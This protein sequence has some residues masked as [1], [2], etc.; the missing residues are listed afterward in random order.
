[1]V[2]TDAGYKGEAAFICNNKYDDQNDTD[3]KTKRKIQNYGHDRRRS[4]AD[5][6]HGE[7]DNK[8]SGNNTK[9]HEMLFYVDCL[10]PSMMLLLCVVF[11]H[12]RGRTLIFCV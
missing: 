9:N 3:K 1:M 8:D 4:T 10:W 12:S 7:S 6:S 11:R 2:E 5:L